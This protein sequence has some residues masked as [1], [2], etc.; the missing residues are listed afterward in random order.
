MPEYDDMDARPSERS[1]GTVPIGRWD[2]ATDTVTFADSCSGTA[3]QG[4]DAGTST[5]WRRSLVV[6]TT[7]DADTSVAGK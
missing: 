1:G 4:A 3:E 5:T 6:L 7:A 2:E